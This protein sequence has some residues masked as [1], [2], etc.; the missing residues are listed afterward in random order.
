M[1]D[2]LDP[3]LQ[4]LHICSV[5]I[6]NPEKVMGEKLK[7][8]F[9]KINPAYHGFDLLYIAESRIPTTRL[10]YLQSRIDLIHFLGST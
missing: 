9:N 6:L 4:I 8:K 1:K 10:Q 7:I 5:G 2:R 3:K